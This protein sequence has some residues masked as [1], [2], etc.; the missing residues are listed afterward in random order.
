MCDDTDNT[1]V[2]NLAAYLA[3]TRVDDTSKGSQ[4]LAI[5]YCIGFHYGLQRTQSQKKSN[6]TD[7][8]GMH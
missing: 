8:P 2:S 1:I 6:G 5:K 3:C 4:V 7:S